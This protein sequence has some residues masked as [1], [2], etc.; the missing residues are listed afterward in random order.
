MAPVRFRAPTRARLVP[1]LTACALAALAGCGDDDPGSASAGATQGEPQASAAAPRPVSGP[2]APPGS[3]GAP[4]VPGLFLDPAVSD[5]STLAF[6]LERRL[7]DAALRAL[8]EINVASLAGTLDA[9]GLDCLGGEYPHLG[10]FCGD[11]GN[12]SP[13]PVGEASVEGFDVLRTDACELDIA[14]GSGTPACAVRIVEVRGADGGAARYRLR[15]VE[16]RPVRRIEAAADPI[17]LEA[18]GAPLGDVCRLTLPAEAGG[19]VDFADEP[20]C[21][22]LLR[23]TLA[24]F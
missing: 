15:L 20:V 4:A 5:T 9:D 6:E 14:S 22:R 17:D 3:T 1:A 21:E 12:R 23:D 2:S 11:D 13:W 8:V 18:A 16:G 7:V 24:G 10:W 19:E